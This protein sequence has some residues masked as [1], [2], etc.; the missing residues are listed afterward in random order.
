MRGEK[1]FFSP[2]IGPV[3][4][5]SWG[6]GDCEASALGDSHPGR[7]VRVWCQVGDGAQVKRD[8]VAASLSAAHSSCVQSAATANWRACQA[9]ASSS[10]VDA[11]FFSFG[12]RE[13]RTGSAVGDAGIHQVASGRSSVQCRTRLDWDG[14]AHSFPQRAAR[15]GLDVEG[16]AASSTS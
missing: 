4:W 16:R 10:Q 14:G 11:G 9:A 3:R 12:Q 13:D 6:T 8:V 7:Q 5:V 15:T 1:C 2:R